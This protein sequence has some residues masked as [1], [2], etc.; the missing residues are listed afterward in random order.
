LTFCC[1]SNIYVCIEADRESCYPE[2]SLFQNPT[3]NWTHESIFVRP[4]LL[5]GLPAM[6]KALLRIFFLLVPTPVSMDCIGGGT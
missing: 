2:W 1:D 4:W 3:H 5:G 6:G